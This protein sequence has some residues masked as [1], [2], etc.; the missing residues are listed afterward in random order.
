ML[1]GV[2][3]KSSEVVLMQETAAVLALLKGGGA[4]IVSTYPV[5]MGQGGGMLI[6]FGAHKFP[7]CSTLPPTSQ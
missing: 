1:S 3:T 5:L 7:I 6:L 2:G 4:H